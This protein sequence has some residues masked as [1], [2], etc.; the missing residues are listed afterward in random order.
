MKEQ[1]WPGFEQF[2]STIVTLKDPK[3]NQLYLFRGQSC[4]NHLLPRITR[5]EPTRNTY[6]LEMEMVNE[7][8]FRSPRFIQD[9]NIN[10][11][12]LLTI[13]QH[14]GMT[15]RLLDWTTNPLVALWF[16][17]IDESNKENAHFYIY[18]TDKQ[19]FLDRKKDTDIFNIPFTKIFKPRLNNARI[20]AQQGWFSIHHYYPGPNYINDGQ[21]KYYGMD[22][23]VMHFLTIYHY[24]IPLD[25]KRIIISR[26]NRI[27][28]NYETLFPDLDGLCKNI[29]WMN[30]V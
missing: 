18:R 21:G 13:A 19:Y 5:R 30:K 17:C 11:L 10:D 27:G 7:L 12:D 1:T 20:I 14:Y 29:N 15:T 4:N 8:R 24:E 16:G 25:E 3:E 2:I 23:D 26:L 28:I 9:R 6:S 22:E